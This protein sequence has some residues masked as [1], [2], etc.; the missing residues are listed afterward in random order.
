MKSLEERELFLRRK[1]LI[2]NIS[3]NV[4]EIGSGTGINFGLYN[5]N[6]VNVYAIEPSVEMWKVAENKFINKALPPHI[7]KLTMGLDDELFD[8]IPK[9]SIDYVICTLVLC[10][11]PDLEKSMQIIKKALKNNGKLLLIEHI[12][13]N[14]PIIHTFQNIGNPIWKLFAEGCNLNRHTDKIIKQSGLKLIK[15]EYFEKY[16]NFYQA[17]FTKVD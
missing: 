13:S 3:G 4:L 10:T 15:E 6:K 2:N 14:D 8:I 9:A 12:C 1:E 17:V 11:I 7:K 16:L 5:A